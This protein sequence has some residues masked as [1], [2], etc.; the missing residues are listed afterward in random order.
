MTLRELRCPECRSR[1][2]TS[3]WAKK[4]C[5]EKCQQ[6]HKK[7]VRAQRVAQRDFRP[8]YQDQHRR[9][10]GAASTK[11]AAQGPREV[12]WAAVVKKF[13]ADTAPMYE[14]GTP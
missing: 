12:D 1:F 13:L 5:S 7:T 4:F 9:E 11:R 3:Y 14:G 10:S 6:R 2:R 8:E